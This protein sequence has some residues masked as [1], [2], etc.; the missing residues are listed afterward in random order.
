[1]LSSAFS[2]CAGSGAK[3]EVRCSRM[4]SRAS[5]AKRGA[6]ESRS[7]LALTRRSSQSTTLCPRPSWPLDIVGRWPRRIV[8]RLLDHSA[9]GF[10][11]GWNDRGAVRPNHTRYTTASSVDLPAFRMRKR[12]ER[13]FSKN[14]TTCSLKN[15]IGSIDGR[16][17]TA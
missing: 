15:T 4:A 8:E 14:I 9:G 10:C 5:T 3:R 13:I 16:P 17:A 11:S 6:R 7:A 1:M 2:G 12:S